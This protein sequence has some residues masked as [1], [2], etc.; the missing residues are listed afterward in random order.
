MRSYV[1]RFQDTRRGLTRTE[2]VRYGED[3][4][5]LK[6]H[7]PIAFPLNL[8]LIWRSAQG[9]LDPASTLFS[10]LYA[11]S[12]NQCNHRF[13]VYDGFSLFSALISDEGGKTR[14]KFLSWPARRCR[15]QVSAIAGKA[16][17]DGSS[18]IPDMV[19]TVAE[20]YPGAPAMPVKGSLFV[21]NRRAGLRL[22]QVA[23]QRGN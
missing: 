22:D 10:L 4:P 3:G 13:T 2:T 18:N 7:Q 21:G 8:N 5:S 1:G 20:V 15:L 23:V 6:A 12:L 14:T 9:S 19:V 17:V 11:A 16:F